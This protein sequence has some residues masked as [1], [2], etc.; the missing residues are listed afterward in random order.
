MTVANQVCRS[1]KAEFRPEPGKPGYID[2]CPICVAER[3]HL[4]DE[5]RTPKPICEYCGKEV[6]EGSEFRYFHR[7][8]VEKYKKYR[9]LPVTDDEFAQLKQLQIRFRWDWPA[10]FSTNLRRDLWPWVTYG[11]TDWSDRQQLR[12]LSKI[13][14]VVADVCLAERIDD[15]GGRFFVND[16]GAFYKKEDGELVQFV[17][18]QRT[19][20]NQNPIP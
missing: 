19:R 17:T 10:V 18:F 3:L 6:W 8:C 12:G 2:E 1:C 7:T 15:G 4:N 9:T 16:D 20:T 5:V 14:D 11:Y 13:L